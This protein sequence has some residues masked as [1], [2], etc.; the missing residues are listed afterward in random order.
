[1]LDGN[2]EKEWD[3]NTHQ[4]KVKKSFQQESVVF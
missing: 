1:M 2:W 3:F 4:P